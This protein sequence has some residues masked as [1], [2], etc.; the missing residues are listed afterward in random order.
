MTETKTQITWEQ[1]EE[2]IPKEV[3]L[4]H[5]DYRDSFDEHLDIIQECFEKESSDILFENSHDWYDCYHGRE[6]YKEEL[7]S[8]LV[9]HFDIEESTAQELV[10]EYD[11]EINQTLWDRD[12]STPIAD[13]FNNTQDQAIYF[14]LDY[15]VES[16]SWSWTDAKIRLE[17]IKIKD[18]L[19]ILSHTDDD[20][21]I[22]L[23]IRQASYGGNLVIYFCETPNVDEFIFYD[24]KKR[25][26]T[27]D[28]FSL[29]IINNMNGSGDNCE[30]RAKTRPFDYSSKL[31]TICKTDHY[32][33]TH[34]VCAMYN[35]WCEITNYEIEMVEG[36]KVE[37]ENTEVIA[38]REQQRK[39]DETY[40]KG[41]CTFGDMDITRHRKTSYRNDFPCGTTCADCGTFWI[42]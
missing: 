3:E 9:S 8:D 5:I 30:V 20:D 21:D 23:M 34:Q 13:C 42:D 39:Y 37:V 2:H 41:G 17:R 22:D 15:Y 18:H 25:I 27:F 31:L 38:K 7:V 28:H 12:K 6:Y 16:E 33:Y 36:A 32:S 35:N 29:A 19:G 11:D 4:I 10:E 26:I 1:I 14:D 40:K 24:D